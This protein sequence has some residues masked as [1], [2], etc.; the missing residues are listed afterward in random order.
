MENNKAYIVK[1]PKPISKWKLWI[2]KTFGKKIVFENEESI[3]TYYLY[4]GN[5]YVDKW[6]LKQDETP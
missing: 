1:M 4:K 3:T 5:Y 2:A 6:E